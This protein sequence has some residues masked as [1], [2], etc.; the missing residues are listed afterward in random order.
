MTAEPF[1]TNDVSTD[2]WTLPGAA[3][4]V[5][6]GFV[7]LTASLWPAE[8][9]AP[10]PPPVVAAP[11]VVPAPEPEPVEKEIVE[12]V[13]IVEVAPS[14]PLRLEVGFALG[15]AKAHASRV[16]G[17]LEA[18]LA[19]TRAC[20][21]AEIIVGGHADSVGASAQN[22]A[23]SWKRA[24]ATVRMMAR[25]GL[26]K[27][28]MTPRAYGFYHPKAALE[29]DSAGQ[30]RVEIVMQPCELWLEHHQPVG[31]DENP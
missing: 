13:E 27:A 22:L 21:E 11:V 12:V 17:D 16:D 5:L 20:P 29:E 19:A 8:P 24:R 30:R 18:F 31:K 6:S 4:L 15:S 25:R 2:R 1:P 7:C 23:L 3:A 28:R 14:P 9:P 26:D 10:S